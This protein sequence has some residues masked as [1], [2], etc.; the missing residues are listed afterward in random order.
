MLV[1]IDKIK[2]ALCNYDRANQSCILAYEPAGWNKEKVDEAV[3][4]LQ[5]IFPNKSAKMLRYMVKNWNTDY[6]E[7]LEAK[8]KLS[9]PSTSCLELTNNELVFVSRWI[10]P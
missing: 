1:S 3:K 4:I 6:T 8:V 7:V 2:K 5:E 10:G 9:P